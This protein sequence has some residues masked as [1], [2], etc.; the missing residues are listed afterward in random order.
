MNPIIIDSDQIRKLSFPT[1]PATWP[2][3]NNTNAGTPLATQKAPF[4]S[5][6]RRSVP[7][8]S[9]GEAVRSIFT[10]GMRLTSPYRSTDF[11]LS[12]IHD[13]LM[14]PPLSTPSPGGSFRGSPLN[15]NSTRPQRSPAP[16]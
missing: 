5:I 16:N 15:F 8:I 10:A 7:E 13:L 1:A 4:Q 6:E 9:A 3:E 12:R 14:F 11:L 2:M